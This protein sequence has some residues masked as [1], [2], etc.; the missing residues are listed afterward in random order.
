M[1]H[2]IEASQKGFSDEQ[3]RHDLREQSQAAIK[4][5]RDRL[6]KNFDRSS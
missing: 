6:D 5:L 2:E 1:K 4:D 3:R